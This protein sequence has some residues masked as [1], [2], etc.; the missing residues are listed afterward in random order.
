[1]QSAKSYVVLGQR[2]PPTEPFLRRGW[3]KTPHA[4]DV[5]RASGMLCF[6]PQNHCVFTIKWVSIV[7]AK[8]ALQPA[9]IVG[10]L[11]LHVTCML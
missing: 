4:N 11:A 1:M 8:S 7:K 5:K 2:P 10:K 9:P 3:L 6:S